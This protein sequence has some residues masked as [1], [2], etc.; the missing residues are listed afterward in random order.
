[1]CQQKHTDVQHKENKM[2]KTDTSPQPAN[3]DNTTMSIETAHAKMALRSTANAAVTMAN[4]NPMFDKLD[5]VALIDELSHSTTEVLNGKM[6]KC[7]AMLLNQA[8]ALQSIFTSLSQKAVQQTQLKYYNTF[9]KLALKAQ[10]QCR[11]TLETL[12]NLKKPPTIFAHQANIAQGHQQVNNT[13]HA[14]LPADNNSEK[15]NFAQNEL[16][17]TQ[18]E[19]QLELRAQ[20]QTSSSH[21]PLEAMEKVHRPTIRKRQ[22]KSIA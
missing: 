7:E 22:T 8:Y 17:E 20:S 10:S 6:D 18:D 4:Y 2:S 14:P 13:T 5:I 12:A 9:L 19:Q 1:M 3:N 15:I 16:L 21:P 11:T